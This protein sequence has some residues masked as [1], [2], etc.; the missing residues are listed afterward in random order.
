MSSRE[1]KYKQNNGAPLDGPQTASG[2]GSGKKQRKKTNVNNSNEDG[3]QQL[4]SVREEENEEAPLNANDI[5]LKVARNV[6]RNHHRGEDARD[7]QSDEEGEDDEEYEYE[8]EEEFEV[9]EVVDP[10]NPT[11]SSVAPVSQ[12]TKQMLARDKARQD[13]IGPEQAKLARQR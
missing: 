10:E 7:E 9:E 5:E 1:H 8:E 2:S 4:A 6:D 11:N 3:D 12:H 13:S